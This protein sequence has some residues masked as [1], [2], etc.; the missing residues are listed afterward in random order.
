MAFAGRQKEHGRR[1]IA[2]T[3]C[4]EL[5]TPERPDFRRGEDE[6]ARFGVAVELA[7]T[8]SET[9]EEVGTDMDRIVSGGGFYVNRAHVLIIV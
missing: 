6:E 3:S 4:Y 2:R 5:F 1:L 8:G 7:E 9:R